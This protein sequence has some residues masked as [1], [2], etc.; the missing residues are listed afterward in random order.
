MSIENI[1]M[2]NVLKFTKHLKTIVFSKCEIITL[3][4]IQNSL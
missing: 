2:I 1:S 4:N 3:V